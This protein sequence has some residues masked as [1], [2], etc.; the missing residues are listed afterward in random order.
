MKKSISMS[1]LLG[2]LAISFMYGQFAHDL[3]LML[4]P[5]AA[6]DL[7]P[8]FN[9]T[10]TVRVGFGIGNDQ[11]NGVA[12]QPDGKSVSVGVHADGSAML[13]TLITR[14]NED[15]SLDATFGNSG[16]V[17]PVF[18]SS[19]SNNIF[20]GVAIQAD[21]RIVAVGQTVGVGTSSDFAVA[22]YNS[23]GTPD[24]TFDGD[25]LAVTP[26]SSGNLIDIARSVAIQPDGKIVVAGR[27]RISEGPSNDDF[28]VA[29]YNTDG[30]LDTEFDGD[31]KVIVA[32]AGRFDE[33]FSVAIQDDEKI[34]AAGFSGSTA[35]DFALARFNPN[36]SLDSTFD[37]DGRVTTSFG[38]GRDGAYS[39]VIQPDD[40]IVA[41]GI[42][43]M[44][45][46][47][48]A[49]ARYNP[50]GSLDASF[51]VD[52][53]ATTPIS[54]SSD[55]GRSVLLQADGK[56]V[57]TGFALVGNNDF[58]MAR[59]NADGS[60]DTSFDGDGKVTTTFGTSRDEALASAMQ[61]DGKIIAV[62][63]TSTSTD[64]DSALAR[65]N[66]NGTLDTAFD[67]DGR[68]SVQAGNFEVAHGDST[69]Q[70][71][72]KIISVG[73]LLFS[74]NFDFVVARLNPNGMLDNTFD[75]DG[76]VRTA[77]G[78]GIDEARSVSVQPDGKIVVSGST[79]VSSQDNFAV[80]RYNIDGTL[81]TSFDTDGK[82]TTSVVIGN[83]QAFTSEIQSDEK[84]VVAG[85]AANPGFF[86]FTVVRYNP[87]GTLDTT[88]DADGIVTTSVGSGHSN[89][90]DIAIQKDGK[91][92]AAGSSSNGSN[93]DFTVV[94]YNANGSLD[95]TFDLDGIAT[96]P[97]FSGSDLAA[98]VAL[99]SDG[100]IVLAGHANNGTFTEIA[101]VRFENDGSLDT[102][103]GGD[104]IVTTAIGTGHSQ[105]RSVVIQSDDKILVSGWGTFGSNSNYIVVRYNPDGTLDSSFRSASP[106]E[107]F[108]NG[109]IASVDLRNSDLNP[110]MNLQS[111][112]QIV[113]SGTSIGLI[114]LARLENDIAPTSGNASISGRIVDV[115]GNGLGRA[116]LTLL[117][118]LRG[119]TVEAATNPFGYF[120]FDEMQA[121]EFYVLTAD[122]KRYVFEPEQRSFE[123]LGDLHELDFTAHGTKK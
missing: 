21:G 52:G 9:G 115:N 55:E 97:V 87:N 38:A 6:G 63:L 118:A 33:A 41:A 83:D 45:N 99:Q 50:D 90:V 123:L 76:R 110:V 61:P 111:D 67:T 24:T 62:G 44:T 104:G 92:I 95:T 73:T 2:V 70:S 98:S 32:F 10:G 66:T 26:I 114:G 112:G 11:L 79:R 17:R 91:I 89:I 7:D 16:I 101:V 36:G 49:I 37:L 27:A 120:R 85:R 72:G 39:V 88:F 117:N 116:R 43:T 8:T 69:I 93:D 80:V 3:S 12:I 18:P 19:T 29:R 30:S 54:A 94:R 122:H 57:V 60:L 71:D 31:G 109:G 106:A 56:L 74:G 113:L 105:A 100:K 102:S 119:T 68:V 82:V 5:Q 13:E 48:F 53:L 58:A 103:F 78:T 35:E 59:Y 20:H 108:G 1:V 75:G 65:Y 64:I 15:G 28:A 22:R 46:L 47:D 40:K 34:V 23:D 121:G 86:H 4:S 81:D 96:T 107:I 51:D 42:A 84:I 14:H 77:V 25:G